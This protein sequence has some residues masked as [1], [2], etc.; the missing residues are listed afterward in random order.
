MEWFTSTGERKSWF[1]DV[2]IGFGRSKIEQQSGTVFGNKADFHANNVATYIGG[3]KEI[4]LNRCWTLVPKASL[5]WSYY[6]QEAFTDESSP[7]VR[8]RGCIV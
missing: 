4:R 7:G 1:T 2:N 3:G 8:A 6:Y 5:L